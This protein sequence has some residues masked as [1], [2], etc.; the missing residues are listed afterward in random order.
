M[1][2]TTCEKCTHRPARCITTVDV[3]SVTVAHLS[4]C[5]QCSDALI[6][7]EAAATAATGPAETL[8][9]TVNPIY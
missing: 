2:P 3:D 6:Q 1:N 9:I 8:Q 7:A 5:W 4:V